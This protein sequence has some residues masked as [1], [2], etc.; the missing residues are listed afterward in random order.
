MT[1]PCILRSLDFYEKGHSEFTAYG[2]LIGEL[3]HVT[4]SKQ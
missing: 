2:K 4:G 1:D 3:L